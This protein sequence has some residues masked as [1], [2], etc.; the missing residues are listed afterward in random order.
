MRSSPLVVLQ[1]TIPAVPQFVVRSVIPLK[2]RNVFAFAATLFA[3][4]VLWAATAPVQ[5]KP[6]L[7]QPALSPNGQEIAFASGGDIWTVPARGGDAHLLI[8]N[9]ATESRPLYSPDGSK[10]AF[11]STRTGG[12]D[13]YVLTLATGQL[14][15]ITYGDTLEQL[16]A[17]SADGK[18]IYFTNGAS[19]I[20]YNTDV[21][22]VSAEGGTPMPVSAESYLAEFE[23]APSPD[24][25]SVVMM[26][27][28]I[29][30]QQWWRD[31]HAHI[32]DTELWWKSLAPGG[33]YR[34]LV[35]DDAKH[36]WPMWSASG[37]TIYYMSDKTGPENLWSVSSNGGAEKQLT[38]FTNGR[39]LWPSIG[40]HGKT[41]VFE[42]D[43]TIWKMNTATGKA[44][45]VPV[46]L[47]GSPSGVG[48]EHEAVSH[49]SEMA[50]SPDGKKLAVIAHGD[51]YVTTEKD[52]GEAIRITH[53]PQMEASLHWSPDSTKLIYTSM[54][55][56]NSNIYEYNFDTDK[57]TQLTHGTAQCEHPRWDPDGKA[58][59]YIRERN[60]VHLLTLASGKDEVL[61][62]DKMWSPDLEFSPAG[63]WLAYTIYGYD[64]FRNIKVVPTKGGTARPITFLAN[65][66]TAQQMAWSPDGKYL[67]FA[68]A[69]RSE[70]F[71][72]ARVDL[73]LHVPQYQ[74]NQF[75][76][77][78]KSPTEPKSPKSPAEST[79]SGKG[80]TTKAKDKKPGSK[81]K[82]VDIVF[83]GI[84]DRLSL[85]PLGLSATQP[86]ISPDGKTLVFQAEVAGE[87]NLYSWSLKENPKTPPVA[88]QLTASHGDKSNVQFMPDS[89]TIVFLENGHVMKL[90]VKGGHATPIPVSADY[91]VNFNVEKN[92]VFNEAW[93]D[94]ER[95]YYNP[96]MNG[97]N[98]KAVHAEF[99]P[100]IAGVAT[101]DELRSD[102]NLM[103][104]RLNSSHSGIYGGG[105][106][107][108]E[109][110]RL[111][112]RFDR[113]DYDAGKG[114]VVSEVIPLSPANV[115]GIQVGDK[116]ISVNGQT[117]GADT[118][119]NAL[120]ENTIGR[121]T[122][123]EVATGSAAPRKVIVKPINLGAEKNLLYRAW[124]EK[125]RAYVN[126]ISGGKL[127][128]VHMA[129][130][131]GDSLKQLYLDLDAQNES[132][133][134][135]IVDVRN[136][137][138]GFVNGYAIDVFARKNYLM[139]TPRGLPASPARQ[140]LGQRALG[141][142]TVLV[143]N[144][145][146]LSDG[147]DFTE[148][149]EALHLG[150]VVGVPT[151]GWIIYTGG[152]NLIDGSYLRLPMIEVQTMG[153]QNMEMH[154]RPVNVEVVRKPGETEAGT[155]S[156]LA[157][158]VKVLLAQIEQGKAGAKK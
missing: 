71:D 139:L 138:G 17:W 38:H 47:R 113:A 115:G 51:V 37:K 41:I 126:K 7:T 36:A 97:Q 123:L 8:S 46:E 146:T 69:Q 131:E 5:P 147:E 6:S 59:A 101:P 87:D 83:E 107:A 95:R 65:G 16:D 66:E 157:A 124:V 84:R 52:G 155:D 111:G 50:L 105:H 89:K 18:W 33:A 64:G 72:M 30:D 35:P 9:P 132:K 24:G 114:L 129:A 14:Q 93:S 141:K 3:S 122:V 140:L 25:K 39:V 49:F 125:E 53:T 58:I 92:V 56:G 15:R 91:T 104:G 27:K 85:L 81:A 137:D 12:G 149:Y 128:Y 116:L 11:I 44:E 32:D 119:F 154:P 150:K 60:Q 10:I 145:S 108:P 153:G 4:S 45:Q 40:D 21:Y 102:I 31:G 130:M 112:L 42:R 106:H 70:N 156:Q 79:T 143:T 136:N 121:R 135:V 74:E 78:F 77:L 68:T 26:A 43:L 23:S 55:D 86:V 134:G 19:D 61:A 80:A 110:G 13:I 29:S 73:T 67:L 127:G 48:E 117:I 63:D 57:E 22:R 152:T 100:F 1:I 118:D 54:R 76:D 90:A 28:G 98:W 34:V 103:I 82:P 144:Q 20:D 62:T 133:E 120:M 94:L 88:K 158:A 96:A 151:A 142:P 99:A 109:V 75:Y 2:S 148:G